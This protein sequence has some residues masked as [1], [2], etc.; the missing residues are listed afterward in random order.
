MHVQS[1]TSIW[2]FDFFESYINNIK[3]SAVFS[4]W[5]DGIFTGSTCWN[6]FLI[7][8]IQDVNHNAGVAVVFYNYTLVQSQV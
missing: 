2:H 1:W 7:L 4:S 3:V 8:H 5:L 6:Y